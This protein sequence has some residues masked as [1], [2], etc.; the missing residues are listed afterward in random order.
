MGDEYRVLDP[1]ALIASKA[2]AS[3]TPESRGTARSQHAA[4]VGVRGGPTKPATSGSERHGASSSDSRSCPETRPRGSMAPL[5]ERAQAACP[6]LRLDPCPCLGEP[7]SHPGVV[8]RHAGVVDGIHDPDRVG[9][10][11]GETTPMLPS[12]DVRIA[13][14]GTR[15]IPA[16][17]GGFETLAWELSTRLA[18]RGHEVRSTAGAAGRTRRAGA[19]RRPPSVRAVPPG[20]VPRDGVAHRVLGPGQ[21]APRL[22]RD[23]GRQ[24]RERGVLR[25]PA[26]ARDAGRPQRRRHR[27][28]AAQVGPRRPPLVL[29]RRAV[30]ADLPERDRVRR[31]RH[32]RLLPRAL[33]QA[34][35]GHRVRRSAAR[36]RAAAGPRAARPRRDRAR[37]TT[38]STS[39]ASSRRTR[40]TW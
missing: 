19:A 34:V 40:P 30:R 13:I 27:T 36:P 12:P 17:Y 22:R 32:P 28:P 24:R 9:S 2:T 23:V 8:V 18:E 33:R 31:R 5:L 39:A 10:T 11:G 14:V 21:P 15:G 26:A 4:S 37:R 29:P 6:I 20:Q 38:S 35:G 3:A 16:A 7:A 1:G 25:G